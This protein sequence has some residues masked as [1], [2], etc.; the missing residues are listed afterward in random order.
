MCRREREEFRFLKLPSLGLALHSACMCASFDSRRQWPGCLRQTRDEDRARLGLLLLPLRVPLWHQSV[1][2]AGRV[3]EELL[4]LEVEERRRRPIARRYAQVGRAQLVEEG[5]RA[6]VEGLGTRVGGVPEERADELDGVRRRARSEDL[7][8]RVRLDLREL[9]LRVVLV[10]RLDLVERRRAQHLDDLD[11]LV[12]ARLARKEGHA[13]EQLGEHAARGPDVDAAA[14]VGGA[15]DE[16]RRAVVARADVRHVWLPLDQDLCAPKVAQLEHVARRVD[17][18]VLRLDVAVADAEGVDVGERA[19]KLVHVQL[20]V[21][22]REDLLGLCVVARESVHSLGH[23]VHHKVEVRVICLLPLGVE[24]VVE[25]RHVDVVVEHLHDLE[26]A[27]LE[28]LVLEHL[29]DGHLLVILLDVRPVDDAKG[30]VADDTLI[31]KDPARRRVRSAVTTARPAARI[32]AGDGH[33]FEVCF[34]RR[35]CLCHRRL[36]CA[37]AAGTEHAMAGCPDGACWWAAV[38]RGSVCA[39]S[40][41]ALRLCAAAVLCRDAAQ[42]APRARS[43]A[44]D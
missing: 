30:A 10:H 4:R 13:Q 1:L 6:A 36:T 23:K 19:A 39:P 24:E 40:R 2:D 3:L 5:H 26:L 44:A 16:L 8:P 18:Q 35:R 20:Q 12:D 15:K 41:P 31:D 33:R 42:R 11:Q 43:P 7:C 17:E 28:A 32:A 22:Q 34:C 29:L 9:V 25:R 14:V 37:R 27:V 21:Q 38:V